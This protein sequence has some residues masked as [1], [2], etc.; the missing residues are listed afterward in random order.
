MPPKKRKANKKVQH[1]DGL[2][3]RIANGLFGASMGHNEVHAPQYTEKG[4][5]FGKFIGPGT[6]VYGGI[7]KGAKPVSKTDKTAKLHDIMFTLAQNPDDVRAADL[8]M[9]KNLDR[10]QKEKGDYK[11]NIYMGKLPIKGKMMLEDWG[12]MKKGSFS[13]MKGAK[14]SKENRELLENEKAKLTQEG[15]GKKKKPTR[16]QSPWV[17]HVKAYQKA[18]GGSYKEAMQRSRASY[19]SK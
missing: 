3:D 11:F 4:F 15:Y 13:G 10:I 1:G 2:Y 6:D 16:L 17:T 8:R 14:V 9:V 18:H 5:R 19:K 7:R 12:I